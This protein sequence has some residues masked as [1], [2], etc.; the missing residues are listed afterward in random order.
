MRTITQSELEADGA[1]LNPHVYLGSGFI[2]CGKC[3]QYTYHFAMTYPYP[4]SRVY[5]V[6]RDCK[7][8]TGNYR[9]VSDKRVMCAKCEAELTETDMRVGFCTQCNQKIHRATAQ[10]STT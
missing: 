2:Y 3:R 5:E 8:Y 1:V 7:C 6:C 9:L 10:R 4:N